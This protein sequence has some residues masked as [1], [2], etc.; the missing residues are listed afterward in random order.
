MDVLVSF[1]TQRAR[2]GVSRKD[3]PVS[4]ERLRFGRGT[5][6]EVYLPDPRVRQV[7]AEIALRTAGPFIEA[8]GDGDMRVNDQPV[9]SA[10][11]KI[12]DRIALGPY[13]LVVVEPTGTYGFAVTIELKRALGDQLTDLSDRSTIALQDTRLS[14]RG[15][16]WALF[17][18]VALFGLAWPLASHFISTAGLQDG[19]RPQPNN[20]ANAPLLVKGDHFWDS[21]EISTPHKFFAQ[22]C[23]ACHTQ[24][25]TMVR[26]EQCLAC[27][28]GIT[29]HADPVHFAL[30]ELTETR[31]ATCHKEH[32]GAA[33][34]IIRT[35]RFCADCHTDLKEA[36]NP[37]STM[38]ENV[39]SFA[40]HPEF[41]VSLPVDEA[42]KIERVVLTDLPNPAYSGAAPLRDE[43][44]CVVS[45]AIAEA[46]GVGPPPVVAAA[47]AAPAKP[48]E[49]S[50]L[51]F[52]H[53]LHLEGRCGQGLG[54]RRVGDG[55]TPGRKMVCADCHK[56]DAGGVGL[57]P[58]KFETGCTGA[59]C[60]SLQFATDQSAGILSATSIDESNDQT[61]AAEADGRARV[62]PHGN[63]PE[64]VAVLQDFWTFQ[65]L[66]GGVQNAAAPVSVRR[67]PGTPVGGATD[68]GEA[69]SWARDQ[70]RDAARAVL[71][72]NCRQCH[73]VDGPKPLTVAGE[74]TETWTVAAV[75]LQDSFLPK[76]VFDHAKH[77]TMTCVECH[78]A[79]RSMSATD[80][81]LP[82]V[83]SCRTCHGGE[84]A[85]AEVPST[86]VSCH[87]FHLPG[88]P[89]MK[90]A[91]T[92]RNS[93]EAS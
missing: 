51:R 76:G 58:V 73:V 78:A 4:A 49:T 30:P 79:D 6:C 56:P 62:L 8:A 44:G 33:P 60:H 80:T 29:G 21:G 81:L 45:G 23:N 11:L 40:S 84:Q 43:R 34:V 7:H 72:G 36:A 82:N 28:E 68:R 64:V 31:C 75:H 32:N 52:P 57:R 9:R 16:S 61:K 55:W 38:L 69:L 19:V 12:G 5:E 67:L 93:Q 20:V 85:T 65:A 47:A 87:F 18:I 13:E 22:Q 66:K 26:D 2:G 1:L 50:N 48:Q 27:H 35:E 89:P 86:C 42:G 59:G 54:A 3:Q 91:G 74:Q 39:A 53:L 17:L 14:K 37:S 70:A 63:P 92:A 77:S 88:V 90:P 10:A 83:E 46:G 15:L 24:A 25:F 41:R 71:S